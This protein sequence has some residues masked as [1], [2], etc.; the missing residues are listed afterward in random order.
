[1]L[2]LATLSHR[3]APSEPSFL[4]TV[5]LEP[6]F[7]LT[8]L[9]SPHHSIE[10]IEIAAG[11][12]GIGLIDTTVANRDFELVWTPALDR[13]PRT[14]LLAEEFNG[15][16]YAL[17]M[18]M[19]PSPE[20]GGNLR[21]PREAVFVVDTSGSMAGDSIEQAREAL[22]YALGA[23]RP[24]DSFNI[25]RFDSDTRSL[26]LKAYPSA[27]GPLAEA[28]AFINGLDANGGTEMLPALRS[29]LE[30][31]ST[32]HPVR[33]VIFITDGSISNEASPSHRDP[34]RTRRQS[35]VHR[36]NRLGTQRPLHAEG[37]RIRSGHVYLHRKYARRSR[38]R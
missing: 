27:A 8:D 23:L 30:T 34:T 22:R 36:R 19:P 4:L 37:R 15:E 11:R 32:L 24:E 16:L 26:Y 14:T 35:T 13:L 12:Y 17:L 28:E 29:A 33:Q 31:H 25:I 38:S 7:P 20:I 1:M 10:T 3:A 2:P 6:G 5:D 9:S 21:L 18:M